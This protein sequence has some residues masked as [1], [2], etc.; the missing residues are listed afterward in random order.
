MSIFIYRYAVLHIE[1]MYKVNFTAAPYKLTASAGSRNREEAFVAVKTKESAMV[2]QLQADSSINNIPDL[3]EVDSDQ[4][5]TVIS[6]SIEPV[7]IAES[8]DDNIFGNVFIV[9]AL[10]IYTYTCIH[11]ILLRVQK[12]R[13]RKGLVM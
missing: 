5:D 9:Q 11:E 8:S 6:G 4:L 1:A 3:R 10:T 7:G 2:Y 13:K 12:L